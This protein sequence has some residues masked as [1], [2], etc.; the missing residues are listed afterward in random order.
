MQIHKVRAMLVSIAACAIGALSAPAIAQE[1]PNKPV[2]LIVPF[3]PGGTTDVAGRLVAQ[4]LTEAWRQQV[5][6]DNRPGAGGV[7][8]TELAAKSTPDGYTVLIGSITTHAVNPALY[9]KLNFDPIKDFTPVSLV[10]SSPQLLAVHPSV[11]ARSVSELLALAKSRPGKLNYASAGSGT[12]P[13]LT[14]ELFKSMAGINVVHVPYK[15]TGPAIN[16]L[17]GGQVQMMITGV[18]ALIPHIK[19]GRLRG[20]GVT[21]AKRVAAL[22]ELPTIIESGIAGFDVSSWF[23]VFAP[24]AVPKPI[25]RKMN[26]EIQRMLDKEDIRQRLISLGAD[27]AEKNSPEQFS[28]YVKSEMARW[29]KVVKD[30]GT[31][32]N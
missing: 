30:T 22:P 24:G 11:E 15:G 3:P 5:I 23:G 14:F 6:V 2:R 29:S 7:I 20:V 13:H 26:L 1:Y 28:V 10:V 19:S 9:T 31:K 32:V 8:G 4:H 27:P 18:V 25:V 12:S 17:I 21:S 16:D